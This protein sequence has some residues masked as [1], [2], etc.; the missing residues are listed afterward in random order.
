MGKWL[1][2]LSLLHHSLRGKWQRSSPTVY[3]LPFSRL[4]HYKF[5]FSVEPGELDSGND[6]GSVL[7]DL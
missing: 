3:V 1:K 7:K 6:I 4:H 2:L 5:L